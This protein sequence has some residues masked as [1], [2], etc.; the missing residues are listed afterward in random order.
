[1]R[2]LT[3]PEKVII[4]LY[5][6]LAPLPPDETFT[7]AHTQEGISQGTGITRNHVP[8]TIRVLREKKMLEEA[9]KYVAGYNRQL[10]VY[11]L[12][13]AGQS[14]ASDL[15]SHLKNETITVKSRGKIEE[16][17]VED[18]LR[19]EG[20]NMGHIIR[21][22]G[23][24]DL[25]SLR[26]VEMHMV[27]P[28][29]ISEFYNRNVE[30]DEI[31]E[32]LEGD[33][34][35]LVI[36]GGIGAG[37]SS[38]AAR[39]VEDARGERNIAWMSVAS[40]KKGLK[41]I[42][43]FLEKFAGEIGAD[44]GGLSSFD[45]FNALL[46]L[47]DWHDVSDEVVEY[48]AE[49][50]PGLKRTDVK[51]MVTSLENTPS[52]SRFYRLDDIRDGTVEELHIRGL[53]PEYCRKLL[54]DIDDEALK[55]IFMMTHGRPLYIN[56]LRKGEMDALLAVSSFTPEEVRYLMFLAGVRP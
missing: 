19:H 40:P 32:F 50:L 7:A 42:L 47:D 4:H 52:Y 46:V 13:P 48:F 10:K 17:A 30:L 26:R 3:A 18:V 44:F 38:L 34:R 16:V 14:A 54:G 28:P 6:S 49:E 23:F 41:E 55:K 21:S 45:G 25:D 11:R 20:I 2:R 27:S 39:A 29:D 51:I 36:Y 31:R 33:A 5:I 37:A 22:D 8:R 56:L 43:S 9:R 35:I 1:M 24:L 12:T 53:E 15:V